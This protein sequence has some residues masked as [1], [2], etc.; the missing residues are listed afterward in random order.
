MSDDEKDTYRVAKEA[1]TE[2]LNPEAFVTL[3]GRISQEKNET[4]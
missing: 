4:G 1:L 2:K 3:P